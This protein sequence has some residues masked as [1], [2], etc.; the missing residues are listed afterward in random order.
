M[1]VKHLSEG[2]LE[3]LGDF[4]SNFMSSTIHNIELDIEVGFVFEGG[5]ELVE[6]LNCLIISFIFLREEHSLEIN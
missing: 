6:S 4:G 3:E 1:E 5:S 2:T